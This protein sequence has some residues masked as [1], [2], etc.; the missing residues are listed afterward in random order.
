VRIGIRVDAAATIGVGHLARCLALAHALRAYGADIAFVLRDL[1]FDAA[2]RVR[3][4]GFNSVVLPPPSAKPL[5]LSAVAHA[6]WAGVTAAQDAAETSQALAFA[7]WVIIDHYAFDGAWHRG[8]RADLGCRIAAIDDL[9]DRHLAVDLVID[10]NHAAD[11]RAKYRGHVAEGT[12]LLG[13]PRYALL[14]PAFAEA[15]RCAVHAEVRSVGVFMGGA[16]AAGYSLL[17]LQALAAVG[18]DGEV[19]VVSTAANPNLAPLRAAVQ[20][21]N[22]TRLL[23]DQADLS[24]FFARHD[25]QV[26]ASGVAT[27]ERCCV[28]APTLAVIVADNQRLVLEPLAAMGVLLA[29]DQVPPGL[30]AMAR[31]LQMLIDKHSMRQRLSQAGQALVDGRGAS[32]VANYLVN[33]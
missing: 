29:V 16:D 25:L 24:R 9:G 19:E 33:L 18:F 31:G 7:D 6:A 26:G 22:L 17:A 12:P 3:A 23:L 2:A 21:R 4:E 11:H 30:A 1:G 10:H 8:V 27:W 5:P 14:Q 28:G 13:G 15:P 32:R 20:S